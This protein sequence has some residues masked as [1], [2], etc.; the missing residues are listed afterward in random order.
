MKNRHMIRFIAL[1]AMTVLMLCATFAA[2]A[3]E[4]IVD[5]HHSPSED[6]VGPGEGI[7]YADNGN[8]SYS[9]VIPTPAP[10]DYSSLWIGEYVLA[11]EP[12]STL[13][14][15]PGENGKLHMSAF[16]LRKSVAVML[17]QDFSGAYRGRPDARGK[18]RLQIRNV[19]FPAGPGP[20]LYGQMLRV[21]D[22]PVHIENH[23]FC[24]HA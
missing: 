3:M 24:P 17:S 5:E 22:H 19:Q 6:L 4:I 18:D 9:E 13:S 21:E 15:T 14:I 2:S 23:C 10:A 16:F 1:T 11:D 20:K 7:T 12:D 8:G